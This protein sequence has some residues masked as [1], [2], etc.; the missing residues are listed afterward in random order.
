MSN[1][2]PSIYEIYD[3]RFRHLIVPSAGL[4]ELYSDCRWAE[5]P[6]WFCR[7]GMSGLERHSQ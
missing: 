7:C 5:G 6:V 1:D 3:T 4:E 2:A